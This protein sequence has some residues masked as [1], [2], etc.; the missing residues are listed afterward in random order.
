MHHDTHLVA[1]SAPPLLV[2][3]LAPRAARQEWLW[4]LALVL[5]A[6]ALYSLLTRAVVT[7]RAL[8]F[9]TKVFHAIRNLGVS[10]LAH[11]VEVG[12]FLDY[13]IVALALFLVLQRLVRRDLPAAEALL[14]GTIG[15]LATALILETGRGERSFTSAALPAT[16]LDYLFP[17]THTLVAVATCS[18]VGYVYAVARTAWQRLLV[19]VFTI[20]LVGWVALYWLW[21]GVAYATDL[22]GGLL[23]GIIWFRL[24]L[25][26]TSHL[27]WQ[28][29][30][31]QRDER[32]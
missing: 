21:V 23:L 14:F 6:G 3:T 10:G 28:D 7:D 5:P 19:I 18:L 12:Q 26:A 24:S 20:G 31:Y 9:D 27:R 1:Q 32:V 17:D 30:N 22:L 11:A 8:F 4:S 15:A 25:L 16:A 13:A 29:A 2:K